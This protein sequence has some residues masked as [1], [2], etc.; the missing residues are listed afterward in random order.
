MIIDAH[1]HF[2]DL[3]RPDYDWLTPDQGKLYR[4]YLPEDLAPTLSAQGVGATVLVQAAPSEAETRYLFRL[5]QA[6][7][8]ISGI[9]GWADFQ[10][11][12]ARGRISAMIADSRGKLK[13]L[14]PMIQDIPDPNWLSGSS[15]DEA[16]EAMVEHDLVFDVLIRPAQI[17]E[18]RARLIRHPNLR[19]VLD[20]AGKPAIANGSFDTWAR[21]LERFARDTTAYCK[22][23][24][25]LTE[26]GIGASAQDLAPYVAHIFHCFGAQRVLWG[27]DWPVLNLVCDYEHWL[28][29]SRGFVNSFAA[30]YEKDVFGGT[31]TRLYQLELP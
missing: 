19:A 14:R 31:A 8:F 13:G 11:A 27:S 25:L 12:G 15:L 4:N 16:F 23:S 7:P 22:L 2:W 6:H 18:V 9:V 21:D 26:A 28:A 5:A 3:S 29:L 10:S 17:D 1:Q 30:R 20:H 24:G